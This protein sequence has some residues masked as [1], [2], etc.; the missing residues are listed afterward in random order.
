V[1]IGE[2]FINSKGEVEFKPANDIP[3]RK[4]PVDNDT[5]GALEIYVMPEKDK[6]GKVFNERY[7]IGHDP[8][9]NDVA[10]S[11]SLSSTFVFDLFT[12][13]IVAEFTG[14]NPYAND[15]FEIVRL[16]CMFYNAKCLYESNLKGIFAYFQ[17]KR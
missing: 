11:S 2:L 5:R 17:M 7:I 16:L 6:S 14:R 10:E 8:V 13:T 4:Y 3:I 9:N 12:D 1:Y 15:N